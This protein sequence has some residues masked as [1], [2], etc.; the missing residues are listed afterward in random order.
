VLGCCGGGAGATCGAG[1]GGG[2]TGAAGCGA[3]AARTGAGGGG[4][5]RTGAGTLGT[6]A[7][8]GGGAAAIGGTTGVV[9][10]AS[11]G[12]ANADAVP[13]V[14]A[15]NEITAPEASTITTPRTRP[16]QCALTAGRLL[17]SS[18]WQTLCPC[19]P[20]PPTRSPPAATPWSGV[21]A[22]SA[23]IASTARELLYSLS[24]GSLRTPRG[25]GA[26]PQEVG[27]TVIVAPAGGCR[28]G[29]RY[30]SSMRSQL[31]QRTRINVSHL[32][33][34]TSECGA[35][36]A[37]DLRGWVLGFHLNVRRREAGAH[38]VVLQRHNPRDLDPGM[39]SW[40]SDDCVHYL[41]PLSLHTRVA[42]AYRVDEAALAWGG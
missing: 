15:D 2:V 39:H 30:V 16:T 18:R 8:G 5:A 20:A 40:D 31:P 14:K 42:S 4:A 25:C 12:S 33:R 32:H 11:G 38:C 26:L 21:A 27:H 10:G 37:V 13:P 7:R 6:A 22:A 17:S 9:G 3:G 23:R 1:R 29:A 34:P 41:H 36:A 35:V 28:V 24:R 19:C